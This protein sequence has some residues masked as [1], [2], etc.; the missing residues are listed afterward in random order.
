[1]SQYNKM[2]QKIINFDDVTKEKIEEHNPN[3]PENSQLTIQNINIQRFGI[4][5]KSS[6]LNLINHET[7][8]DKIYLYAKDPYEGKYQFLINKRESIGFKYLN[9]S[10]ACTEYSNNINNIY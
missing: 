8:I 6:L 3:W 9:H 1:M 4:W 10:K 2:K 5:K 7:D